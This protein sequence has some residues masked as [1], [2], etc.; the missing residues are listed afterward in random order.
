MAPD[1]R[2]KRSRLPRRCLSRGRFVLVILPQVA[3]LRPFRVINRRSG[4]P[5]LLYR[6]IRAQVDGDL[7]RPSWNY[8]IGFTVLKAGRIAGE[9]HWGRSGSG[10]ALLAP[11][12][13]EHQVVRRV[14]GSAKEPTSF[15]VVFETFQKVGELLAQGDYPDG[16]RSHPFLQRIPGFFQAPGF[17]SSSLPR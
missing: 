2:R 9:F 11:G 14:R 4:R 5:R 8:A 13:L 7:A 6:S 10:R 15:L 12:E 1:P 16:L 17:R 3:H